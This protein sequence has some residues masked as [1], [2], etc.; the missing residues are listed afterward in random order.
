MSW[1]SAAAR[2]RSACRPATFNSSSARLA[3]WYTPNEC[4]NRVWLADGYTNSTVPNCLIRR[5]R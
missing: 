4:S 1:S 3:R 2:T 5:S